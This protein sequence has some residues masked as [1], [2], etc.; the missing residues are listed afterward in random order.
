LEVLVFT[1]LLHLEVW[2]L[3][4]TVDLVIEDSQQQL[5][6]PAARLIP[7]EFTQHFFL[8]SPISS[9]DDFHHPYVDKC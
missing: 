5:V 4:E 3:V 6:A 8:F 1:L 9:K 7:A 2:A